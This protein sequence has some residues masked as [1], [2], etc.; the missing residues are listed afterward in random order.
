MLTLLDSRETAMATVSTTYSEA[1]YESSGFL[2]L[3]W[4][5]KKFGGTGAYELQRA[6]GELRVVVSIKLVEDRAGMV[7]GE[8]MTRWR[9]GIQRAWNIGYRAVSGATVLRI[10]FVPMFRFE[11]PADHIVHVQAS[12]TDDRAD[13]SHWSVDTSATTA[14]HEFGHMLGLVDEYRLPATIAEAMSAGLSHD[15]A[16]NSS[17]E[18]IRI[19]E[20]WAS[21]AKTYVMPKYERGGTDVAGIMSENRNVQPR[22]IRPI[23]DVLNSKL[24]QSGEAAFHLEGPD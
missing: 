16:M 20:A 7:T 5:L 21:G 4:T 11:D 1:H 3:G 19:R 23:V 8:M 18:G 15:E 10:I 24:R 17:V 9:G 12:V 2:G 6:P 22:H 14:A 13:E